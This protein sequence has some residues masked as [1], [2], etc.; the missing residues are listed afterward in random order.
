MSPDRSLTRRTMLLALSSAVL[1]AIVA[2]RTHTP[3]S[4]SAPVTVAPSG[5]PQQLPDSIGFEV[6][7]AGLGD[8]PG[9]AGSGRGTG[10]RAGDDPDG[11]RGRH[12]RPADADLAGE[13]LAALFSRR[14]SQ[15]LLRRAER[16]HELAQRRD[17]GDRIDHRWCPPRRAPGAARAS[18]PAGTRRQGGGPLPPASGVADSPDQ[19]RLIATVQEGSALGAALRTPYGARPGPRVG[20]PNA[21]SAQ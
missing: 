14:L 10:A 11:V 19:A 8:R 21:T 20:S 3:G 5:A 4:P 18:P 17:A 6:E 16:E 12:R 15:L 1:V 13:R 2:L 9:L 7:Y